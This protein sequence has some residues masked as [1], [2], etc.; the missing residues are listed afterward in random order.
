MVHSGW[1]M[2][3]LSQEMLPELSTQLR[4]VV[5]FPLKLQLE[6]DAV[7]FTVSCFATV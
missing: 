4:D 2:R 6:S 3:L 5:G 7:Q 1:P